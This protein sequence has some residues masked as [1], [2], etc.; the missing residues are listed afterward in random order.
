MSL[1]RN[2]HGYNAQNTH[3]A[4][5]QAFFSTIT[6]RR[7]PR[8]IYE[9]PVS[10][11]RIVFSQATKLTPKLF[12]IHQ[13][14]SSVFLVKGPARPSILL[15]SKSSSLARLTMLFCLRMPESFLRSPFSLN[16]SF[17]NFSFFLLSSSL[18]PFEVMLISS[19]ISS[20][21]ELSVRLL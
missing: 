19:P 1:D 21:P 14:S 2:V 7:R 15:P 6:W 16:C 18:F 3:Q 5:G 10:N 8:S 20:S 9:G 4:L 11:L 17:S 12:P 13:S